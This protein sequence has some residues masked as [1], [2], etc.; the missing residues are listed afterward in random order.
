MIY[1]GVRGV[2]DLLNDVLTSGVEVPN[3][4]TGTTT[5]ALFDAKIIIDDGFEFVTNRLASPR[6]AFEEMLLFL[7]GQT[8]TKIL[9]SKGVNFW[10]GNT[11]R[12]F[13]DNRGLEFLNEGDLGAAYSRQWRNFGGY[14]SHYAQ[15]NGTDCPRMS[16]GVDQLAKLINGLRDEK[17]GRRHLVTLWNPLEEDLMPLTPCH[18]TSQY[19][20]LPD[21][22]GNDV[23]HVKLINRS[24]DVAFG[25]TFALYQYRML[26][27]MLCKMFGF[28]MGRLSLDISHAHIYDNQIEY[29]KELLSRTYDERE[30]SLTLNK[31]ISTMDDLLGVEWSDW[32]MVYNYNKSPFKTKRPDMVA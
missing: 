21:G 29:V 5:L 26:Q 16:G 3:N 12:E 11:S 25:A 19:V 22:E 28:K 4:R 7:R 8:D 9:E 32:E 27:M 20:V 15:D 23:L 24:L 30:N 31:S 17:Y 1:E 13:L 18:H 10:R 2:D 14:D 6:L